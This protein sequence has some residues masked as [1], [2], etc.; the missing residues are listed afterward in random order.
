[1]NV[2]SAGRTEHYLVERVSVWLRKMVFCVL[3]LAVSSL[4]A[5]LRVVAQTPLL[6][7]QGRTSGEFFG[8]AVAC[9]HGFTSGTTSDIVVGAP[10][11]GSTGSVQVFQ[12]ADTSTARVTFSGTDPAVAG[13]SL[14]PIGDENLDGFADF[15]YGEISPLAASSPLNRAVVVRGGAVPVAVPLFHPLSLT[16]IGLG[17]GLAGLFSPFIGQTRLAIA[18]GGPNFGADIGILALHDTSATSPL[19]GY[20][21][22]NVGALN[23]SA[24]ASIAD[25]TSD[26][27]RD[28]VVGAPGAVGGQGAVAV[29]DAGVNFIPISALFSP[30]AGELGFGSAIASL[31][32]VDSDGREEVLV[33]APAT[34]GRFGPDSGTAYVL[35]VDTAAGIGFTVRCTLEGSSPGDRFG[36]AVAYVGDMD[37]DGLPEFAVGSPGASGFNGSV[38]LYN[39]TSAGCAL[40]GT[41]PIAFK[42]AQLGGALAGVSSP[43]QICDVNNDGRADLLV[44]G[45]TNAGNRGVVVAYGVPRGTPGPNNPS[46]ATLDF[47][48][49]RAGEFVATH[50]YNRTPR[51]GCQVTLYGRRTLPDRTAKGPV[52]QL[53]RFSQTTQRR[54]LTTS[55]VRQARLDPSGQCYVYH[56]ITKST[57]GSK[58]FFSNIAARYTSCGLRPPLLVGSWEGQLQKGLRRDN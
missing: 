35:S 46:R 7:I 51:D 25:V 40:K 56:L 41:L 37:G 2:S 27:T 17:K 6:T 36:T 31:G 33:G 16:S 13:A 32:D 39:L 42:A 26:G 52:R 34:I 49:S 11:D 44:G 19:N 38:K 24:M 45:S 30:G 48:I 47:S 54:T 50:K 9:V 58:S 5:P 12:A 1:M 43:S 29:Y 53:L 21:D 10:G 57:C 55:Q 20:S 3:P 14:A 18:V 22:D 8:S 15:V 23:G 4:A 28:L